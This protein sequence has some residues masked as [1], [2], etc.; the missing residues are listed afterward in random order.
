MKTRITL[1]ICALTVC[2]L[3]LSVSQ[4]T[5]FSF[6]NKFIVGSRAASGSVSNG[7]QVCGSVS[8]YVPAT[9]TSNGSIKIG[10]L[11]Y[12]IAPNV[13]L[14]GVAIGKDLCFAFCF[15]S[16]GSIA[17]QT[18][19]P[20]AGPN[21][22]QICGYVTSFSPALGGVKG[23]VTIGGVK[24]SI[25]PG[26]SLSGQDQVSVGTNSCLVPVEFAGMA[27]PGSF[28]TTNTS[29]IRVPA[30]VHGRTFGPGSQ[31]DTF[32]LPEPMVLTLSS[33]QASVFTVN[34][35]TFGK[36]LSNQQPK[37]QGFSLSV[38]NSTVQ[39][40][41][42][43]ESLWDAELEIASSGATDGDMV[44]VN[45][46]NPDRSVAQQ[47]AMFTV[48][49][50]GVVLSQLHPDV[51]MTFNGMATKG[52]GYF[53]P[54]IVNAGASGVRT[55]TL[56]LAFSPSSQTLNGCF[57][58]AVGIKRS[59]GTGTT[60]VALNTVIVKRMEQFSDRD[61]SINIGR[62]TNLL[63]WY[64]T[65]K[66]CDVICAPCGFNPPPP[67]PPPPPP[68]VGW[69][70]G[71]VYC[72]DN[73]NGIKD[74]GE[75]GIGGVIIKVFKLVNNQ[76]VD[77]GIDPAVTNN[78]GYYQFDIPPGTYKLSEMQPDG[79]MDGKD[80]AGSCGGIVTDDMISNIVVQDGGACTPYN[81]GEQCKTIFKCDT[82]CWRTTQFFITNIR[83]LPGGAILIPGVNANN[84]TGIQ[85]NINA[86]RI[87]L[88]GGAG[89]V[90][91]LSKEFVTAQLSLAYSGGTGSPVVFNTFWSP[92]VCSGIAF[93]PVTLS[94]GVTLSPD[95][96]LDTLVT[97]TTLA[98]KENRQADMGA[99]ADIWWLL[100]GK[101]GQ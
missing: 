24:F 3:G 19:A 94:N 61:V 77:V 57:Q 93:A 69:I 90:Q 28:F 56:A 38:P 101:C 81:F 74:N 42:C 67:P 9:A 98:V 82:I 71:Y 76:Y 5:G 97:Q 21:Y 7:A 25:Y 88:Q 18:A 47:I 85:Q 89:S 20:V 59:N 8:A 91:K 17:G 13:A 29:L 23:S 100:N 54:F 53:S 1:V 2:L 95:S 64:P 73:N 51:K 87:A 16:S 31:D 11:T 14:S 72:D 68:G 84:P 27:G 15:D 63:G 75:K 52:V 12:I 41:S 36:M 10:G 44:T 55:P 32:W 33:G 26:I 50:G 46:L 80:T 43:T 96:L 83:Y 65:G 4:S 35:Q 37:I 40:V 86:I 30:I 79:T 99:L 58:L 48:E 22:P 49:N 34:Q 92:L 66:P 6:I 60:S 70:S 45:L 62:E 39:A 78:N